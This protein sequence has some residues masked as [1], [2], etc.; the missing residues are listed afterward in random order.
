MERSRRLPSPRWPHPQAFPSPP[1]RGE[2]EGPAPKAREGEGGVGKCPGIPHLTP[3]RSP[4]RR[5]G[6]AARG[7]PVRPVD[8][9][10]PWLPFPDLVFVD[11]VGP[12]FS[13]GRGKDDTPDKPFWNVQ[14][15]LDS[16]GAVLRRWLTRH[17]RWSAPV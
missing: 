4:D 11:P 10:S 2:R 12:G 7:P 5:G 14:S 9:Q 16:L 8:N 6:G 15:D 1:L 17:E 3:T 13:R